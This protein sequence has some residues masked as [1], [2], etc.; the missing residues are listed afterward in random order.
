MVGTIR[1]SLPLR[2][3][4]HPFRPTTRQRVCRGP[5]FHSTITTDTQPPVHFYMVVPT[6]RN[7]ASY[8]IHQGQRHRPVHTSLQVTQA[9]RSASSEPELATWTFLTDLSSNTAKSFDAHFH[10][11]F[12]SHHFTDWRPTCPSQVPHAASATSETLQRRGAS[13]FLDPLLP[14]RSHTFNMIITIMI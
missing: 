3:H 12:P 5:S 2:H 13:H 9:I 8:L 6:Q 7:Q 11:N 10:W 1:Q 14:F 4:T